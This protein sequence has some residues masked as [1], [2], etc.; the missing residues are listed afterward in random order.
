MSGMKLTL[1]Y[2]T[3]DD[4]AKTYTLN[5]YTYD[6]STGTSGNSETI[7]L[8]ST[9]GTSTFSSV[10][11]QSLDKGT[12]RIVRGSNQSHVFYVLLSYPESS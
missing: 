1:Y 12:Y 5:Y 9:V 4:T 6:T 10:S 11:I 8:D 2:N 3:N 7:T